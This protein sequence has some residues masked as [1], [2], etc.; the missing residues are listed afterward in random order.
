MT[1]P[2]TRAW[3]HRRDAGRP[4]RDAECRSARQFM[5][6]YLDANV[7]VTELSNALDSAR[8]TGHDSGRRSAGQGRHH[9]PC[10]SGSPRGARGHHG[11]PLDQGAVPVELRIEE[12]ANQELR[13]ALAEHAVRL[14]VLA[15]DVD[16]EHYP[17]P[18]A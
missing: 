10:F 15:T 5:A 6:S 14:A 9:G 8:T 18:T 17:E 12:T 16:D 7:R 1:P 4:L 11:D 13:R 3:S 2:T